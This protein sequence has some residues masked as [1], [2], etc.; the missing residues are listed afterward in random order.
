MVRVAKSPSK[1]PSRAHLTGLFL[2]IALGAIVVGLHVTKRDQSRTALGTRGKVHRSKRSSLL[3]GSG[4]LE[5]ARENSNS[6]RIQSLRNQMEAKEKIV[7]GRFTTSPMRKC[8]HVFLD[9]GSN[10][11]DALHKVIDSFLPPITVDGEERQYVFNTTTGE[12]GPD[13]YGKNSLK[14]MWV[15]P[16]F[17]KD[18]ITAYNAQSNQD[19]VYPEDYCFYGIEGN[20]YFTPMLKE[21]EIAMLYMEP[22]PIKHAHFLTEHVGAAVDG[23]T[24]LFLDTENA[25]ANYWGSSLLDSHIDVKKSG[26]VGVNVMGITLTSLLEQ[27]ALPGGHVMIK[28]D[29]EGAEYQL[30]E[31]AVKSNIFCKLVKEQ[32]VQIS[33]LGEFHTDGVIG[34]EE[35]RKRWE[36]IKG[37]QAILNCG[38]DYKVLKSWFNMW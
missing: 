16:E 33:I 18:K 20:P 17:V 1:S 36:D 15:V 21:Q 34:S 22:R 35:P 7:P 37:E 24:T 4:D 31:E 8:K 5:D 3:H 13:Y 26:K 10:V 6:A 28:I 30:L 12:I 25:K 19:P 9:F 14:H 2:V 27:V 38:V 23:P 11:G 32:G 29:I